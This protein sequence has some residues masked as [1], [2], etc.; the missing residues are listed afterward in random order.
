VRSLLIA[1]QFLTVFPW[2]RSI[3]PSAEEIGRSTAFFPLVGFFLGG[4][5]ASI[6]WLLAA[7]APPEI[8]SVTLVA[9][10][11][12]L[13]RGL[14]L[15]GLADTFD[16]LGA[17]GD[18]EHVFKV[19]NDSHPGVFGLLAIVLVIAF[20]LRA[21]AFMSGGRWQALLLAP[22]VGRWSMVVLG[23]Q[24]QPAWEGLGKV[25][26]QHMRGQDLVLATAISLIVVALLSGRTGLW[27]MLCVSLFA[28]G[29]KKYLHKRL[30]G[31]TGDTFGAVGELSEAS[32]LVFFALAQQ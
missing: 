27:I 1:L 22:V 13:T 17:G 8:L 26:V 21:I 12:L 16:G 2:L 23:Y 19:M 18:R 11:A 10:L 7:Y 20:K 29:S 14:H 3:A 28:I 4:I 30:G 15:D 24:S 32:A 9:L 25:I 31:V 6:N 5:L